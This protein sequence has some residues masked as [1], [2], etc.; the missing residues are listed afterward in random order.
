MAKSKFC[1]FFRNTEIF[2]FNTFSSRLDLEHCVFLHNRCFGPRTFAGA[3]VVYVRQCCTRSLPPRWIS[4][5]TSRGCCLV[6][7]VYWNVMDSSP[8][9]HL[10]HTFRYCNFSIKNI[11]NSVSGNPR[12]AKIQSDP[13]IFTHDWVNFR[14][15]LVR[16]F[17]VVTHDSPYISSMGNEFHSA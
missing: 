10:H 6:S 1:Y 4:Y 2:I 11:M 3:V 12:D 9:T 5:F 15:C 7:A 16:N 17:L 8:E 13:P 14:D